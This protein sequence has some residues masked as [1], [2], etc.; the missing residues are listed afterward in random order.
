MGITPYANIVLHGG[1]SSLTIQERVR[2]VDNCSEKVK[3]L[4]GNRY[5]HFE[6]TSEVDSSFGSD[7]IVYIWKER[8]YV[9]E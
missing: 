3:L 6:P 8:T 4:L 7:L 2:H 9:A 1:P 5:E